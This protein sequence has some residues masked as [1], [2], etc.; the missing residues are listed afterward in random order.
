M[1]N[2]KGG[3]KYKS[4]K[5]SDDKPELHEINEE[6][7][8]SIGRVIKALGDRNMLLY[9]NDGKERIAHIRGGLS[10]KKGFIEIGDIVLY[11]ERGE[12]LS[13]SSN[14]GD[15][16]AKYD[17]DLHSLLKK[18]PG[19]NPRLF[20]NLET[21]DSSSRAKGVTPAAADCGFEFENETGSEGDDEGDALIARANRKAEED[22]KRAAA[23]DVKH[24]ATAGN[25]GNNGDD[26]DIDAI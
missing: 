12:G 17:R 22:K 4:G 3:K 8:Q 19:V 21:L 10:K 11:S 14:R 9:C 25:G 18:Q 15:I 20:T 2:L 13:N 5:H 24:G 23:R 16:L 6:D 1:P 26:V 7:G